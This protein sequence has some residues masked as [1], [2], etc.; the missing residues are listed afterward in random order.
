MAIGWR[1]EDEQARGRR[2]TS[3]RSADFRRLFNPPIQ[4]AI[5]AIL[6]WKRVSGTSQVAQIDGKDLLL[7]FRGGPQ[8]KNLS[9]DRMRRALSLTPGPADFGRKFNIK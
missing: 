4:A 3:G 9:P 2:L 1:E 7:Y 6:D 8:R 5:L